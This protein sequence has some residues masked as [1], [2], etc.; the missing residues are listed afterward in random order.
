M[1][2]CRILHGEG[3]GG[4]GM[5]LPTYFNK[6]RRRSGAQENTPPKGVVCFLG[7]YRRGSLGGYC[8]RHAHDLADSPPDCRHHGFRRD[9]SF[10]PLPAMSKKRH[11]LSAVPFFGAGDEARSAAAA[12]D[13]HTTLPT[14]PRTVAITAAAV[15]GLSS[16]CPLC[17]KK[18]TACRRCLFLERATRL[19]LATSTLARSRSTR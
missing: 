3:L 5:P 6:L 8:R 18:G 16:L 7:A 17:P 13:T 14:V 4:E 2:T 11:R 9:R 1:P 15:T 12:A 10:E 19:E